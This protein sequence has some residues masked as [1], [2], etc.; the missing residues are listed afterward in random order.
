[1]L[2]AIGIL[3]TLVIAALAVGFVLGGGVVALLLRWAR[4]K[5]PTGKK[6]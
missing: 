1:M 4:G 3:E 6:P 5:R 2:G